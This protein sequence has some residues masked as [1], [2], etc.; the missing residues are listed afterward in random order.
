MEDAQELDNKS[1]GEIAEKANQTNEETRDEML[2]RHRYWSILIL[3]IILEQPLVYVAT[4][5]KFYDQ[6]A[7]WYF[8]LK[9][10]A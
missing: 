5:V 4:Q 1:S 6:F 3:F 9:G 7:F 2:S 10:I 8:N